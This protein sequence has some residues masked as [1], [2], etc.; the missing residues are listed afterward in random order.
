MSSLFEPYTLRSVTVPNRVWMP[1]MCQ[2]SAAPDGLS[3]GVA[4]DWHFQHY[5]ARAAGGT[6]LIIVEA[7]GIAPEGRIS[8]QDLGLWNETQAGGLRRIT[9]FLKS[10]GTVPGIQLAHAGRKASTSRPWQGDRPV[11]PDEHGW[12]PVGPSAEPYP[13]LK[14]PHALTVEEIQDT[15]DKWRA[16]ARLAL[17][18]G[19]QVVEIHGAHGYLIGN[20]LS[21][22]SNRRTD[23]YGGSFENR[24]RYA[25]E[26]VD[27]VREVWPDDLPLFFRLSATDWLEEGGWTPDDSVALARVLT[28]HG[29]DL[30]DVSTGGNA[31][32]VT[33]PVGPDYQVPFAARIKRETDMPVA[34]VGE[35]SDPGQA[36]KIL[37]AGDADAVLIGRQLLREPTWARRAAR[38]LGGDVRIPPQYGW[39]P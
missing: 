28:E 31:A 12:T 18:A 15:L 5:G 4:D 11:G 24:I 7:T 20:F 23:A 29:V 38:E 3:Q 39:R 21:P 25:V 16:S 30:M 8:P 10:Q 26:V 22:H 1:P 35:I 13:G 9:D 17:A 37:A 32:G 36:E 2:Y 27:A 19:F 33:I 34:A 6:G 14:V